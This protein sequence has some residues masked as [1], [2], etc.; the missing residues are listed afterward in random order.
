MAELLLKVGAA[1]LWEDGDVICAFN[2]RMVQVSHAAHICHAWEEI[3]NR[4]NLLPTN[5]LAQDFLEATHQYKFE[6]INGDVT[7][8]DL[9]ANTSESVGNMDLFI[10]RRKAS[11]ARNGAPK[12]PMF[13]TNGSEVWYGGSIDFTQA[14]VDTIWTAIENK[15]AHKKTEGTCP[16]CASRM[17][18]APMGVEDLKSHLVLP[19]DDFDDTTAKELV[20]PVLNQTDTDENGNP[21]YETVKRRKNYVAWSELFPLNIP[22]TTKAE[23]V[24]DRKK[25]VDPRSHIPFQRANIV[26]E[27]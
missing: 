21:V 7:R 25:T 24:T 18:D 22:P 5:A 12:L 10:A 8:T 3:P 15:T 9:W 6:R 23:N 20:T 16:L 19:V 13:G 14:K 26:I 11:P 2:N 4:D 17:I 1:G 27:K